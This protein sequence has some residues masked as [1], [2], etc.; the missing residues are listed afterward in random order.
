MGKVSRSAE[1]SRLLEDESVDFVF[2]DAYHSTPM[3][4]LHLRRYWP[5][6]RPGGR[7]STAEERESDRHR[8]KTDTEALYVTV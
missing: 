4:L 1:A 6:L 2:V 8:G 3:V 5:K 7:G